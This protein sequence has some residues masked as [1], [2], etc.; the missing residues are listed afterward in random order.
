MNIVYAM[1]R[2]VYEWILPSLRSLKETNPKAK[3]FILCEDD[4][5][6]GL[7]VDCEFINVSGQQWFPEW[8]VNYHN[9]FSYIN[10]LKVVLP[11]ILKCNKVIWL[12]IDTIIC[13]SLEGMWKTDV[14]GKWVAAVPEYKGHYRPFG[15][16]YYNMG[17]ALL[18]LQQMRKDGAEEK[19]A[20]YLNTVP[21]PFADQD[22]WHK[23]GL[24]DKFAVLDLRYN[25]NTITGMTDNPA[26]VHYCGY[27]HWYNNP[28]LPRAGYMLK[29]I[30]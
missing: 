5:I 4:H 14:T 26:I 29:Y 23:F 24:P 28:M 8:G 25:E 19:M 9:N 17:V 18:N 6:D 2:E 11:S 20:E 15:P 10:L 3:V 1:T 27:T 12:D 16:D 30:K 21:Q 13:D 7:P 22:A